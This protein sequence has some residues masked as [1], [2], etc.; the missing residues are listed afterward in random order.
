MPGRANRREGICF[1]AAFPASKSQFQV[2]APTITLPKVRGAIKGVEERFSA[3]PA[4]GTGSLSVP[5]YAAIGRQG[6]HPLLS[7][8][9]ASDAGNGPFALGWSL[10]LPSIARKTD[11]GFPHYLEEESDTLTLS[12]AE[13][14]VPALK[15]ISEDEWEPDTNESHPNYLA[16][17]YRPRTEGLFARIERRQHRETGDVFWKSISKDNVAS[18]YGLSSN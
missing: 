9:Y 11:K 13:D 15:Q 10:S 7:L 16:R 1:S 5:L 14:V 3:N 18:I 17:R 6:F 8:S 2:S 12:G 4:T